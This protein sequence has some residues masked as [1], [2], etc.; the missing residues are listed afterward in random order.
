MRK[1]MRAQVPKYVML[2]R[3]SISFFLVDSVFHAI[4][5]YVYSLTMFIFH[6]YLLKYSSVEIPKLLCKTSTHVP[7]PSRKNK[8]IGIN[9]IASRE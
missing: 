4:F 1:K 7:S 8:A 2:V 9:C 6:G 5:T 3:I